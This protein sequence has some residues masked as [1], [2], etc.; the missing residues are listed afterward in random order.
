MVYANGFGVMAYGLDIFILRNYG[1]YCTR[2]PYG[3]LSCGSQNVGTS[4]DLMQGGCDY[5]A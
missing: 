2:L 4:G 5:I 1:A 3:S